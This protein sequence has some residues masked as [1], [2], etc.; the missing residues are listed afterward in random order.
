MDT[1]TALPARPAGRA[2]D[3]VRQRLLL[4]VL[5]GGAAGGLGR[6]ALERATP[7]SG[8]GWPWATFAANVVGTALLAYFATRLQERLPPSTYPRPFLGTGLC[9]ALTTFSTLQLE[10]I[11]LVRNGHVMLGVSYLAASIVAGLAVVHVVTALVRRET[12]R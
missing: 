11:E 8:H 7:A 3:G 1:P 6:A 10:T 4:A 12:L 2:R 9:G 5:L